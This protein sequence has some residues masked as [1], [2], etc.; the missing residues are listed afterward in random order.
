MSRCNA[1]P[2]DL[3]KREASTIL[4]HLFLHRPWVP[5]HDE[6]EVAVDLDRAMEGADIPAPSGGPSQPLYFLLMNTLKLVRR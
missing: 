4:P 2:E 1:T 5:I 6:T 3:L